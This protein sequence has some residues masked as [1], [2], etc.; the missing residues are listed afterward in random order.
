MR[1]SHSVQIEELIAK[2]STLD[3]S[4]GMQALQSAQSFSQPAEKKSPFSSDRPIPSHPA[5]VK[6]TPTSYTAPEK[7]TNLNPVSAAAPQPL[8]TSQ[9]Q[10]PPAQKPEPKP[11]V[12]TSEIYNSTTHAHSRTPEFQNSRTSSTVAPPTRS[13]SP[14]PA[15]SIKPQ[16]Q[17]D[18]S[19]KE[20]ISPALALG[21]DTIW[22]KMI[23]DVE[24]SNKPILKSY[25]QEGIPE[26]WENGILTIIFDQEFEDEHVEFIKRDIHTINN[27]LHLIT[28]VKHSSVKI[29]KKTEILSPHELHH[30]NIRDIVEVK[31]KVKA[32]QYV[33][34][35]MDLFDGEIVD[36]RG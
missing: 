7:K 4:G 27:C 9:P 29:E 3:T 26:K 15:T 12:P 20:T 34:T 23:S 24:H 10:Q 28:G 36:V 25:M 17:H 30:Q 21:P 13:P 16:V 8:R 11:V 14:P 19:I 2:L 31:N 32:N 5:S 33:K 1:Y 18:A 22:H 35:V 6:E